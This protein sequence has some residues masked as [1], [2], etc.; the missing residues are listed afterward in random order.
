[1][2]GVFAAPVKP[3]KKLTNVMAELEKVGNVLVQNNSKILTRRKRPFEDWAS[4]ALNTKTSQ[5]KPA[6]TLKGL[7]CIYSFIHSFLYIMYCCRIFHC[8]QDRTCISGLYEYETHSNYYGEDYRKTSGLSA[9]QTTP[10]YIWIPRS[11][12]RITSDGRR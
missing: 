7:L 2:I 10:S 12:S 5:K 4:P 8:S 3:K 1:M 6:R 11:A 9:H